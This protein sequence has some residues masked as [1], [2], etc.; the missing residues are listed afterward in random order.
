VVQVVSEVDVLYHESTFLHEKLERAIETKHTTALQ[1]G[2]VAREAN[3]KQLLI[4]HFSSRYE[5]LTVLLDE[6]KTQ[7]PQTQIAEEGKTFQLD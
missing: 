3:V 1:A 7:F 4:G 5:D 6:A 2:M